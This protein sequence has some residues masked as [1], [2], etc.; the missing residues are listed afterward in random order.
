MF[1]KERLLIL[2]LRAERKLGARRIQS[3]LRRHHD[4]RLSLDS[5]HKVLVSNQVSPLWRPTRRKTRHRYARLIP[6]DPVQLDTCKIAPGYYQYTAVDNGT[7]YRVL[8]IF[9][10]RTATSTLVFLERVLEEMPCPVQRVQ[11]DRGLEF[12]AV[13]VQQWLRDHCI[14]FRPVK[15]ASPHLNGKVE[16]SHKTDREEFWAVADPNSPDQELR[17]AEWQHYYNWDRPHG[18]LN[19]QTPIERLHAKSEDALFGMKLKPSTI[20]IASDSRLFTTRQT[21]RSGD[22]PKRNPRQ[23]QSERMSTN[24]TDYGSRSSAQKNDVQMV[25][26]LST[27]LARICAF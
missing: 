26:G 14:K 25:S 17:F 9:R 18:S 8:A 11:T 5:I 13:S 3:E 27:P 21:W 6:G 1:E 24:H 22:T 7:R 4:L 23:P 20:L 19:G 16:R 10:R 15:P 2:S 12:F